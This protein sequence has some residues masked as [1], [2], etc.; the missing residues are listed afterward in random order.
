MGTKKALSLA[1]SPLAA[2][3]AVESLLAAARDL[4][5]D[6]ELLAKDGQLSA[7]A[8][9]IRNRVDSLDGE[10]INEVRATIEALEKRQA[11]MPQTMDGAQ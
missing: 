4:L 11:E 10:L 1:D 5:S 9:W 2:A 7:I 8:F 3:Y 6:A